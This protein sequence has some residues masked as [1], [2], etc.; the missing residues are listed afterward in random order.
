A[1]GEIHLRMDGIDIT[2]D[3]TG[4]M[5]VG[6]SYT[7]QPTRDGA[8]QIR[9]VITDPKQVALANPVRI[10]TNPNNTGSGVASVEVTVPTDLA[11]DNIATTGQLNPPIQIVFNN[12]A[13]YSIFDVSNP[14]D[15]Q[16]VTINAVVQS[17]QAFTPGQTFDLGGYQITIDQ[18]PKAGD[19]FDFDFNK[20]GVSDNR[21]ALAL[22]AIQSKAL[23]VNGSLQDH[24]SG[25]VEQ[26]GAKAAT[27]KINLT[28]SESV[29]R[30]TKASLAS[31]IGVNLDEEAARLVQF[32]QA[33]QASARVISTSQLLFNTLLES[34]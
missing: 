8:A 4:F 13:Q 17:N 6:D 29:L 11:F 25:I 27:G 24:Y 1:A 10:T 28:A 3:T 34:F 15:P 31:I 2:V 7:V 16:P 26:V 30:S 22:S 18:I 14:L 23:L 20:D 21:N 19:R 9:S 12:A 33:Y 32:Q 5:S